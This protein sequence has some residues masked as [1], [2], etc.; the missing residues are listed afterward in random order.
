MRQYLLIVLFFSFVTHSEAGVVTIPNQFSAGSPARAS[1]VNANFSAVKSAV[2]DNHVRL[3]QVESALQTPTYQYRNVIGD[4]S[5]PDYKAVPA[6]DVVQVDFADHY[7]NNGTGVVFDMDGYKIVVR[8]GP[9]LAELFKNL[10]NLKPV[11]SLT[12]TL[13]NDSFQ[14]GQVTVVDIQ[15]LGR[16]YDLP[17]QR[18]NTRAEPELVSITVFAATQKMTSNTGFSVGYDFVLRKKTT[19]TCS[20]SRLDFVYGVDA[21]NQAVTPDFWPLYRYAINAHFVTGSNSGSAGSPVT[22]L[23]PLTINMPVASDGSEVCILGLLF[24][25]ITNVADISVAFVDATGAPLA[26]K[27][28]KLTNAFPIDF[29]ITS[30]NGTLYVIARFIYD[31]ATMQYDANTSVTWGPSNGN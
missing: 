3:S 1:E 8:D 7:I 13:G 24:G 22:I 14:F 5:S 4:L 10:V 25:G 16:E 21:N 27:F 15:Y 2:D 17:G 9:M 31:S 20:V 28:L 11:T 26:D 19:D 18:Q 29:R 6:L 12:V 23:D 30:N